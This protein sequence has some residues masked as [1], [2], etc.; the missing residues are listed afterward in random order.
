MK[1]EDDWFDEAADTAAASID[2]KTAARA[3]SA[4]A[5]A[6]AKSAAEIDRAAAAFTAA[7]GTGAPIISPNDPPPWA[8]GIGSLGTVTL[9]RTSGGARYGKL[10]IDPNPSAS[11]RKPTPE[12]GL[13]AIVRHIEGSGDADEAFKR[14]G[15]WITRITNAIT[16]ASREFEDEH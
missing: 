16:T 9:G 6:S 3:L 4:M 1:E 2:A 5:A 8:S 11:P 10:Q 7:A 15:E 14:A 12:E 13:G